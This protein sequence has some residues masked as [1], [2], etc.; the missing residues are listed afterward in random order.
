[1]LFYF[2]LADVTPI[3]MNYVWKSS[4]LT[5]YIL[6]KYIVTRSYQIGILLTFLNI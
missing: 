6:A 1:M 2:N 4:T 3:L 5:L